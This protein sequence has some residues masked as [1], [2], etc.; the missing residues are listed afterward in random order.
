MNKVFLSPILQDLNGKSVQ[1]KK[2][3]ILLTSRLRWRQ[4]KVVSFQEDGQ[5]RKMVIKIKLQYVTLLERLLKTRIPARLA[6]SL[7]LYYYFI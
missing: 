1:K 7:V 3:E 4:E 2:E 5:K 6:V